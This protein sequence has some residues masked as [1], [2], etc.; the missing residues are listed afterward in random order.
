MSLDFQVD[1]SKIEQFFIEN[2]WK[3]QHLPLNQIGRL[4]LISIHENF[5]ASGR[6]TEWQ[7]RAKKSSLDNWWPLLM[8]TK[9]L[10][11]S[12]FYTVN[13]NPDE[14]SVN[15]ETGTEYGD[16][17]DLGTQFMPARPFMM[18]QDEDIEAIEQLIEKHFGEGP[19]P[20]AD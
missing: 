19:S 8:K 4:M 11:D 2:E 12:I 17:L 3:L 13:R 16:Y 9:N 15:F 6:P 18:A 20:S 10:Y 7:G 1:V 14:A 5:E